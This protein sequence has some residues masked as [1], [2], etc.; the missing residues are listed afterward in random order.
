MSNKKWWED[1]EV[2]VKQWDL[3]PTPLINGMFTT[4]DRLERYPDSYNNHR[5]VLKH[6]GTGWGI[7]DAHF[8]LSK[9]GSWVYGRPSDEDGQE[10]VDK[11]RWQD[12]QNAIDFY[13]GWLLSFMT[14]ATKSPDQVFGDLMTS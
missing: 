14:Q 8:C 1:L 3:G 11:N 4:Q 6:M 12:P 7:M 13:R 9:D 5:V 10:W 2:T